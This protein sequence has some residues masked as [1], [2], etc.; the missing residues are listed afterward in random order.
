M[1]GL[2]GLDAL[3]QYFGRDALVLQSTQNLITLDK[4]QGS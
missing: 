4:R 2:R 1:L 3:L